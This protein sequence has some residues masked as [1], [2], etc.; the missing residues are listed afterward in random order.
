MLSLAPQNC[1]FM[2]TFQLPF[3]IMTFSVQIL[4]FSVQI[5]T[6][7]QNFSILLYILAYQL[8]FDLCSHD[9]YHDLRLLKKNVYIFLKF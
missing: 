3:K 2:L 8:I 6:L 5:L 1:S 9:I 7:S 4:T